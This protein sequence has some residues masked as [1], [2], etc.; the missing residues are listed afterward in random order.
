MQFSIELN[1]T[2][3]LAAVLVYPIYMEWK[4]AFWKYFNM[5]WKLHNKWSVV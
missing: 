2:H 1:D 3:F 4:N 5:S